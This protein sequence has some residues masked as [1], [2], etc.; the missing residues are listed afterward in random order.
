MYKNTSIEWYQHAADNCKQT[1]MQAKSLRQ[2][3]SMDIE[4]KQY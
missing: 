1:N 3:H 4:N 2:R